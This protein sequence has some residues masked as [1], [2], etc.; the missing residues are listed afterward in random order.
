MSDPNAN[1]PPSEST[2]TLDIFVALGGQL[3]GSV[4]EKAQSALT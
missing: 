4:L 3:S 2:L 1:T